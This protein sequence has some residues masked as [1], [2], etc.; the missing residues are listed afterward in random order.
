L[1]NPD[2]LHASAVSNVPGSRFNQN[3]IRWAG[4]DE[5][6]D[7]SQARVDYDF[8]TTLGIKMKAGRSFSKEHATDFKKS[9]ILNETAAR[10]FEWDTP[11]DKEI[12]FYDDD[13][14][15]TGT[16]IGVV[17][18]FHFQSLHRTIEPL[19]LQVLPEGFNY[20]LAKVNAG[21]LA[22]TLDF[23]EE[24]WQAFDPAHT[25]EFTFLNQDFD[26]LY[27]SEEK[28]QSIVGLFTFLAVFI[29]CMGLLGLSA[30]SAERRIKEIGVRKVLGASVFN[31]VRL[32]SKEFF[33]L[34]LLANI[35]ALPLAYF[36]MNRWLQDFAY[37][38]NIQLWLF[39]LAGG[40]ALVIALLTV[41]TQALRAALAN[42]VESLRYE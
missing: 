11:L 24:K 37:R 2:V 18:D 3:Q 35:I 19:I 13:T 33:A 40:L 30:Y 20:M 31:I 38:I 27:R 21:N 36:T 32:L 8:I 41:S 25:F 17:E 10:Q 23:I 4:Q 7:V 39:V 6:F 26:Q 14:E 15:R 29:A 28:M 1:R 5:N 9:F 12:I 16:V 42:P 34:V 22:A